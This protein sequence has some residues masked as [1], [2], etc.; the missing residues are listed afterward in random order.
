MN[1]Q[2]ELQKKID[3]KTKP[4]GSL[5]GLENLALQIGSIQNTLSPVLKNPRIIVFAA[6]HGLAL[7]GVSPYPREVTYQMVMNFLG[8][9]AAINVFCRS[10]NLDM[11]VVDAGVDYD[12]G[13]VEGLID[14]KIARGTKSSLRDPAMTPEQLE[15]ALKA[16]AGLVRDAADEGCNIVGFGE[17]GIGNTASASLLMSYLMNLPVAECVGRGT[18]WN[19]EGLKKKTDILEKAKAFHGELSGPKEILARVGGFEIAMICGGMIEAAKQGMIILVD[20]FIATAA[21]LAAIKIENKVR[22]NSIYCHAGGEAG[23]R[24]MLEY[25]K[26]KPLLDLG[27]RLGEGTGAA[28][29][30]PIISSAVAF[31]NEMSSFETARVSEAE[32]SDLT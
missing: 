9:G 27:L 30:Y 26:A 24:K 5:G 12:F 31:L 1:I 11:A 16:G 32:E 7:E 4:R 20:G 13:G 10:N 2:S 23:H 28:L 8:G 6:D 21:N 19:D 25:L 15:R 17:M 22:D 3:L 14:R 29:A 18:G